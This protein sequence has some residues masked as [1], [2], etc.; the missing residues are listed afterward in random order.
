[1]TNYRYVIVGGGQTAASAVE[2][3]RARDAEGSILLLAA[4]PE[5]PYERPPLS[6]QLWLTDKPVAEVF[7]HPAAFYADN[8]VTLK[9]GAA[10]TAI[11]AQRHAVRDAQGGEYGYGKLL[12]ATGGTPRKLPIPGGDLPGLCY[13]RTLAD[14]RMLR[15][16]SG[17]G[18]TAVV[19]GGGF[20]GSEIA[21]A[22]V[23]QGVEV[24]MI[25]QDGWLGARVFPQPLGEALTA[26]YR[27]KGVRMLTGDAPAKI[28][29]RGAGFT[30]ATRSGAALDADLVVVGIGI[31]PNLDLG[32]AAG[33][34]AGDGIVVN[35]YLQTSNPDIYAAGDVAYFPEAG[36][37]PRR[38]EHWDCAAT[39]GTHAGGNMA[40]AG[41]K[42]EAMPMFFSDLFEFGYEAAGEVDSR[43]D[44]VADWQEEFKTGVIYYL[45]DNKLRGAMLCNV[46]GKVDEARALIRQG[47]GAAQVKGA[48]AFA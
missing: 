39:H 4:E 44:T 45:R 38:I 27:G 26:H 16:A 17:A 36:L 43:L 10:A 37:G 41:A 13:F 1:M 5:L 21:A 24:T 30:I 23:S 7:P 20:I 9:L 35:E 40:G 29:A 12:L 34:E 18:K 3:I 14:Y 47:V 48:I 31:A 19:V 8:K 25:F 32:R 22:L 15:A 28:E 11:D 6:K 42:F 2:G 33:L 46:W